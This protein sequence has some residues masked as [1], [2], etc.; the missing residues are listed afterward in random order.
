MVLWISLQEDFAER[1][2]S[3]SATGRLYLE[4]KSLL[5]TSG[6][7]CGQCGETLREKLLVTQ[8]RFASA[9]LPPQA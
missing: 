4:E 6:T 5:I 9:K 7:G 1:L 2:G 3:T 8:A